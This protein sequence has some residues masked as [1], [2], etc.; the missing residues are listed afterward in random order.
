MIGAARIR[1][2]AAE[3]GYR[4]EIVEKVLYLEAILRQFV[5]HP[6]LE[7][8]WALKGGT[9]LNLFFLEVP[10]LSVDLDINYVGHGELEA[11]QAARP[12]FEA[13][14]VACCE[15][16]D[17]SVRRMPAE[18]A[19]GKLRLRYTAAAG[20]TASLEVDVNFLLRRP[21]LGLEHRAPR[22]P[23][24]AAV[25][26]VPLL[27]LEEIAAGKFTAL[28]TRRAARDAFDALQLLEL[29]PDLL[30][31][32]GFRLAF[33]VYAAGSRQDVRRLRPDSVVVT[34]VEVRNQLL[35]LLRV[36]RRAFDGDPERLAGR[37]NEACIA[38]MQ[39]LL[40]WNER[41]REFIDRLGDRGEIVA[42]LV[43]DDRAL[44]ALVREQ[45]LLQWKALNVRKF[46]KRG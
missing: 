40:A 7:G 6:D 29:A 42:E 24:D 33:L 34:P 39:R 35:P 36:E 18:H 19:G 14:V 10:R 5:R 43:A 12:A 4:E 31:R 46:R 21:L 1:R 27:A 17:C 37:L 41:E 9:A 2:L 30:D 15:R 25:E 20:G 26:T 8:A 3:S 28:L 22:F 38:A 11:M 16:E 13:A 45:P 44:Q 23:P 32:P